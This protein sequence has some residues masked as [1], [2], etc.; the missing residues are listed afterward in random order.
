METLRRQRGYLSDQVLERFDNLGEPTIIAIV[1]WESLA[2]LAAAGTAVRAFYDSLGFDF[3][4]FCDRN[5]I[6]SDVAVFKAR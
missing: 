5:G 4:A 2:S 6:R 3:S 1:C